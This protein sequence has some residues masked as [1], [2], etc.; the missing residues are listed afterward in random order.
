MTP[1]Q[2]AALVAENRSGVLCCDDKCRVMDAKSG[3]ICATNSDAIEHLQAE[4]ARLVSDLDHGAKDYCVL[5]ERHDA[6]TV[7][8]ARL[9]TPPDDAEVAALV[10]MFRLLGDTE[11][12]APHQ[13]YVAADALT[14]LS[15][16]LAAETAKREAMEVATKPFLG[17][18]TMERLLWEGIQPTELVTIR[19]QKRI[20]DRLRATLAKHG[21]K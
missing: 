18:E 21:S 13:H 12:F 7:E 9:S 10:E 5:M 19:V 2:L 8:V 3:C 14:R 15:H 11:S 4:V 16:T 20:Y 6:L 17:D 1:E